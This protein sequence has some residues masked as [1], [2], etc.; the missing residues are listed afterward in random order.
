M[1]I[2]SRFR[3]SGL[4]NRLV[5]ASSWRVLAQVS[6]ILALPLAL[7]C[8]GGSDGIK[9]GQGGAPGDGGSKGAD[10]GAPSSDELSAAEIRRRLEELLLPESPEI[11]PDPTNAY[12]DDLA[13]IDL[14][15]KF[16]YDTRF[17]GPLLSH[18]NT[19]GPGTVGRSGDVLKVGCVSCHIPEDG[20]VD[21]R[22]TR[23]QLSLASGWTRR[24]TQALL[25]LHQVPLMTWGGKRD[26]AYSVVFGVIENALEFNSSRLFVAQQI[27]RLYKDQYEAVF[28]S[29]PSLGRYEPLEPEKSGCEVMPDDPVNDVC[30][31]PGFE[32]PDVT[33]V[34]VNFGKAIGAYLRILSCGRSRF[35]EWMDGKAEF[36]EEEEAGA[37][38]FVGAGKCSSCHSGPYFSDQKFHNVGVPG[39]LSP[40]TG[41]DTG[42]DKGASTALRDVLAD[43]LN[44]RGP[45]SDG[46]DGRLDELPQDTSA[47]EGAFRTPM[48]RCA[49]RR[50]SYF[51]NGEFRSLYDVVDHFINGGSGQLG[52]VGVSEIEPLGLSKE[53]RD[54]LVA[55]LRT[56]D[57]P[58]PS[59]GILMAPNL[60]ED[61]AAID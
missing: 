17:S 61:P 21:T 59:A 26:S 44:S 40:F 23:G 54:Q 1:T 14:G 11:P 5:R 31:R 24:R 25:D 47:L 27:E 49:G 15:K 10:G 36:T 16:F 46:D 3:S 55:F 34:V 29:L 32:D 51:H 8:A 58:G 35:D 4:T 39:S 18:D 53:Q 56:L 45:F 42:G 41:V 33:R 38:L 50:P 43:E 48:L 2:V 13:A 52:V 7:A 28:G 57:G 60:P 20:Y 22:S 19:G 12:A 6:S 30:V 9:G 37:A